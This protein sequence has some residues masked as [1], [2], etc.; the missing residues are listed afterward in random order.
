[1]LK[2]SE[3]RLRELAERAFDFVVTSK[4][5]VICSASGRCFE[6][7][8]FTPQQML[9]RSLVQLAAPSSQPRV[10]QVLA[11]DTLG[12]YEV[13]ARN[14]QGQ[15]VP[16]EIVATKASL[17]G[18]PVRVAGARDLRKAKQ[19]ESERR[20]LEL[21]VERS[22][23][24]NSIGV[25][26]G[27]IAHDFNNLLVGVMGNAEILLDTLQEPDAIEAAQ[28]I[29]EAGQR[30]AELVAQMLAYAGRGK[31]EQ[32][33][34]VDLGELLIE[35]RRLL[36]ATLSKKAKVD[37]VV[38]G[39]ARVQGSRA[40][41]TQVFMNLLTNASDSLEGKP[42]TIRVSVGPAEQV[43]ARWQNALGAHVPIGER[44]LIEVCDPGVGM[45]E[46]TLERA[47]EP[48]FSTKQSGHGLGLAACLGIVS[49]HEGAMLVESEVGRGTTFSVLLPA[50]EQLSAQPKPQAVPSA[51]PGRKVLVVDDERLVRSQLRRSLELRGY[52]VR[53]AGSG[54]AALEALQ[55]YT[56]DVVVLDM[57]MSDMDGAEALQRMRE[58]G[59]T[60]PVVLAS[61]YMDQALER[62]LE[63]S[64]F[65]GF[66]RKPYAIAELL[67]TVEGALAATG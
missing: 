45:D 19:L 23:R 2:E 28:A 37:I 46:A 3:Q 18:E 20:A 11:D 26:A 16:L 33:E 38:R 63:R 67:D 29:V 32:R 65:Q 30:A 42:G 66:L 52:Q 56:P 7:L 15:M 14:A 31:A 4:D 62:R 57:T 22:Q 58:R 53:E 39:P 40:Q 34:P 60:V 8:G 36:E 1:L 9:G 61:G 35:L 43:D 5:G 59:I 6:V 27:G 50:S 44:V 24:L 64:A 55:N 47:F 12:A 21:Q 25:L 51:V 10:R 49:A 17:D 48:F 41:L 54:G 13:S